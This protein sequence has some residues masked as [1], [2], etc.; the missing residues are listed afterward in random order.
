MATKRDAGKHLHSTNPLMAAAAKKSVS[1]KDAASSKRKYT[2][3]TSGGLLIVRASQSDAQTRPVSVAER[4]PGPSIP[5]PSKKF[6]ADE[7]RGLSVPPKGTRNASVDPSVHE[8]VR[9]MDDEA[10]RLRPPSP[11][12]ASITVDPPLTF[13]TSPAEKRSTSHSGKGKNAVPVIDVEE[14][15][16]DGTPQAERNKTLRADAMT[17]IARDRARTPE[18]NPKS[19]KRRSSLGRGK[20]ISNS[21]KGSAFTL[22]HP[23][24]H[25]ESFY[26]HIDR[27]LP[28]S[29]Q[30]RQLLT[31]SASRASTTTSSNLPPED[32][33]AVKS[34]ADNMVRMLAERRIDVSLFR[35]EDQ[36]MDAVKGTNAQNEK[37]KRWEIVY[38][39]QLQDSQDEYEEWKRMAASHE[40][41]AAKEKKRMEERRRTRADPWPDERDLD[42]RFRQGLLLCK[43]PPSDEA[44][45]ARLPD[46]QFK[47]DVL[48]DNLQAARTA[49]R[50]AAQM[51]DMRFG[52]L[53]A[54]LAARAD[55][56]LSLAGATDTRGLLRA[57]ARVDMERPPAMVGDAA[58]RAAREVQ[59]A[60]REGERRV[61]LTGVGTGPDTPRRPGTP[62]RDRTPGRERTPG[63][64]RTPGRERTPN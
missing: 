50:V 9:D 8:D 64:D 20:R 36:D 45:S 1:K 31:W 63:R 37:N 51:L 25:E 29:E 35:P 32:V 24:V 19:H 55:P 43:S 46:L 38:K 7:A 57:L 18:A 2:E 44:L 39:Q 11:S 59:R 17:A 54:E 56:G 21:F 58:R 14:P 33:S 41:Y 53:D 6:K 26:K 23:K 30:L 27:D 10:A 4:Q 49:V 13:R 40:M 5:P 34:I 3:E 15:L 22:P 28:D 62:R 47:L 12:R 61:T 60:T 52:L 42:G 48:H 16:L